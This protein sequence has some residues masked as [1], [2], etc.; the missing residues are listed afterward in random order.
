MS[1]EGFDFDDG[2]M[3][4]LAY[5]QQMHYVPYIVKDKRTIQSD[6]WKEAEEIASRLS[7]S[8]YFVL[9]FLRKYHWSSDLLYNDWFADDTQVSKNLLIFNQEIK[10]PSQL[11][12]GICFTESKKDEMFFS[13][14]G[15]K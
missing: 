12:C 15:H 14:C 3:E 1:D 7:A 11:V 2:M 4:Q 6:I 8:A 13:K 9:Y 10:I 5:S